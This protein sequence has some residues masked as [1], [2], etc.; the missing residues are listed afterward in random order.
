LN[1]NSERPNLLSIQW[2][3]GVA[4]FMVVLYHMGSRVERM[5]GHEWPSSL[6]AGVDIFFVISGFIMW[7]TARDLTPVEFLRRRIVRIVPLYWVMTTVAVLLSC[8]SG[9]VDG[10]HILA[11]YCFFPAVHPALGTLKPVLIAGWTLNYEMYFYL[12]FAAA[13]L[14]RGTARMVVLGVGVVGP[15]L[16]NGRTDVL[17]IE[18]F[19]DEIVVEFLAGVGLGIAYDRRVV[20]PAPPMLVVLG[21]LLFAV[22]G[23]FP[24]A[25]A[26][27]IPAVF[28]VAGFLGSERYMPRAVLPRLLG[29]SSYSLYLTHS[30]VLTFVAKF[31][32]F[33]VLGFVFLSGL[34]SLLVGLAVFTYIEKPLIRVLRNLGGDLAA[35]MS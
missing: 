30:F 10:W 22:P 13:L 4:A 21:V 3:R 19:S 26:N 35:R 32:S 28:I 23:E 11:S 9:P 18:F 20:W 6:N 29:D 5:G 24:R 17:F 16:L 34:M 2:L 33:G 25:I 14:F 8:L 27:G 12:I 31:W 15:M 7:V 1:T